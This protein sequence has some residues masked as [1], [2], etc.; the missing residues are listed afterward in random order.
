MCDIEYL[1]EK[2]YLNKFREVSQKNNHKYSLI[3]LA[4]SSAFVDII[5]KK[6]YIKLP[7]C[8]N[9]KIVEQNF[10][11]I[12]EIIS[13]LSEHETLHILLEEN[14]TKINEI[15]PFNYLLSKHHYI[16]SLLKMD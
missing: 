5:E 3:E 10:E 7:K 6:S 13:Q 11:K 9:E 12:A 16:I 1:H 4:I 15:T 2:D 14:G 8:N